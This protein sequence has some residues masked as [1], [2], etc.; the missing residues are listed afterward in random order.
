MGKQGQIGTEYLDSILRDWAENLWMEKNADRVTGPDSK[1]AVFT[2][3]ARKFY[4]GGAD[5]GLSRK[6]AR[7][8]R[9]FT[10]FCIGLAYVDR[11]SSKA[12][13][14]VSHSKLVDA[15]RK[16][17]WKN[18]FRQRY[19]VFAGLL[20]EVMEEKGGDAALKAYPKNFPAGD[21]VVKAL[22]ASGYV[23]PALDNTA[24][25]ML[26]NKVA[27]QRAQ[28]AAKQQGQKPPSSGTP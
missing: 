23:S 3:F 17:V 6:E 2:E 15:W 19:D 9:N 20:K 27:E 5:R 10:R 13:E 28:Q 25:K 11:V 7:S 26:V 18:N 21:E 4:P 16:S 1:A 12:A 24:I 8:E 22:E 14:A